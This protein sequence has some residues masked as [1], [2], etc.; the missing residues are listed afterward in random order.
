MFL[1]A[2]YRTTAS[3]SENEVEIRYEYGREG[4]AEQVFHMK[5]DLNAGRWV[6]E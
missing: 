5:F 3:V 2:S 6:I 4:V 1:E